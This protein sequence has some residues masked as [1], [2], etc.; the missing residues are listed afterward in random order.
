MRSV[1]L[2]SGIVE[3]FQE[4]GKQFEILES[5]EIAFFDFAFFAILFSF[6]SAHN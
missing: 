3:R 5:F 2:A 1:P 6:S 4:S